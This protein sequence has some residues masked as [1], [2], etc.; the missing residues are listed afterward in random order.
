LLIRSFPNKK[1]ILVGDSGQKDPETY[2]S[3]A[4]EFRDQ[5]D[6]IFIRE[7]PGKERRK[8]LQQIKVELEKLGIE[9]V[10][11]KTGKTLLS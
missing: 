10:L 1:F 5:V 11:F 3:I 4:K 7:I 2:I 8:K 6:K 9:L